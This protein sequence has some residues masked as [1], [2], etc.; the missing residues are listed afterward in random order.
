MGKARQQVEKEVKS[1]WHTVPTEIDGRGERAPV[2]G[3]EPPFPVEPERRCDPDRHWQAVEAVD[4]R[5]NGKT[6]QKKKQ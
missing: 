6:K 2:P 3:P 4:G 5:E 1:A